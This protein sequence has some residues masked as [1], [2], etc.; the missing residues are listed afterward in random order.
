MREARYAETK[1]CIDVRLQHR[2]PIAGG[3]A[4][5]ADPAG[6]QHAS[7]SSRGSQFAQR[8]IFSGTFPRARFNSMFI[9]VITVTFGV[10]VNSLAGLAFAVFEFPFKPDQAIAILPQ[11]NLAA[12]P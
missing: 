6:E 1:Y 8:Y 10:F 5:T 3:G 9:C 7:G 12:V 2:P 4:V 11:V